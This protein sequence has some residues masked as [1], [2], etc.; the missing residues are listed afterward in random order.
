MNIVINRDGKFEIVEWQLGKKFVW[1]RGLTTFAEAEEYVL[2]HDKPLD[3]C[4]T[5]VLTHS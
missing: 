1:K 4:I 3:G 2:K 5:D